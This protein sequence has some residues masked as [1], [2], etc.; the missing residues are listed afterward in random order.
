MSAMCTAVICP[1][2]RKSHFLT[3]ASSRTCGTGPNF[4]KWGRRPQKKLVGSMTFLMQICA[5][6]K[7]L[8]QKRECFHFKVMEES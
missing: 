5:S 2:F 6:N 7:H 1:D 8:P 4:F 3:A